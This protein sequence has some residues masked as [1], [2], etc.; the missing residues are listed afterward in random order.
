MEIEHDD[1]PWN[2]SRI[3]GQKRPVQFELTK[4]TREAVIHQ[5]TLYNS[6]AL[7]YIVTSSQGQ[8]HSLES[9]NNQHLPL[10]L[11]A[12]DILSTALSNILAIMFLLTL[13]VFELSELIVSIN[14][15]LQLLLHDY[16]Y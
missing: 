7:P 2:N 11:F 10:P 13:S 12:S 8:R 5:K 9:P 14:D 16:T 15:V 6:L 4:G 1:N 3:V